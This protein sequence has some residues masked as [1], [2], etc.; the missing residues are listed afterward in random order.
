MNSA[1]GGE[2]FNSKP[3]NLASHSPHLSLGAGCLFCGVFFWV[4]CVVFFFWM[5]QKAPIC[6]Y[7]FLCK[8]QSL[9]SKYLLNHTVSKIC[10]LSIISEDVQFISFIFRDFTS[11]QEQ[12]SRW[13]SLKILLPYIDPTFVISI[14]YLLNRKIWLG[15]YHCRTWEDLL[16]LMHKQRTS[17]LTNLAVRKSGLMLTKKHINAIPSECSFI[18]LTFPFSF[19]FG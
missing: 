6:N 8:V 19:L 11:D 13:R 10:R 16:G 18:Y 2:V 14:T 1:T 12:K 3:D 4:F 7:A 5:L 15:I 9:I 17:A